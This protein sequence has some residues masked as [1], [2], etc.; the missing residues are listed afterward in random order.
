MSTTTAQLRRLDKVA[1]RMRPQEPGFR[2]MLEEA[3]KKTIA[4]G[5]GWEPYPETELVAMEAQ[6]GLMAQLA[7]ARRRVQRSL[8]P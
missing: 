5:G 3:R 4:D 7:R 8:E 6:G 1:A 2:K